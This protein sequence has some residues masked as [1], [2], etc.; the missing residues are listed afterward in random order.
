[1]KLTTIASFTLTMLLI[2]CGGRTI[3]GNNTQPDGGIDAGD[4]E[5]IVRYT[6]SYNSTADI[7][8][9][10]TGVSMIRVKFENLSNEPAAIDRIGFQMMGFPWMNIVNETLYQAGAPVNT[11]IVTAPGSLYLQQDL[12]SDY[13]LGPGAQV[14]FELRGDIID[15]ICMALDAEFDPENSLILG[16]VNDLIFELTPSPESEDVVDRDVISRNFLLEGRQDLVPEAY[17]PAGSANVPLIA[18][19]LHSTYPFSIDYFEAI[20]TYSVDTRNLLHNFRLMH[21]D[22]N[23]EWFVIALGY[24]NPDTCE[25]VSCTVEFNDTFYT[26][27]ECYPNEYRI[28]ADIDQNAPALP[29]YLNIPGASIEAY[30][31]NSQPIPPPNYTASGAPQHVM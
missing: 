12:L 22:S 18:F 14:E 1:M 29:I 23:D 7:N 9:G 11:T 19:K 26:E 25:N 13:I 30:D 17:V 10:D 5:R 16:P 15:G 4:A 31:E 8:I 6:V 20:V 27:G 21:K 28:T 3:G 2:G 24:I